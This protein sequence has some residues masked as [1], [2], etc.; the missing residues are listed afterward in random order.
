MYPIEKY[1]YVVRTLKNDVKQIFAISSYAGKT[2]KAKATCS[3][4][5]NFNEAKGK[6]L[7]AARLEVKVSQKRVKNAERKRKIARNTLLD[8]TNHFEKMEGYL[9]D[10]KKELAE[11]EKNLESIMK[12]L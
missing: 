3:P 9:N 6:E 10:S 5:D 4:E 7:A 2:V 1:K 8:A 12:S 11:A